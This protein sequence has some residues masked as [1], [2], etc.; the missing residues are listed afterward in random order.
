MHTLI[1]QDQ[2][3]A[4]VADPNYRTPPTRKR[5]IADHIVAQAPDVQQ[6]LRELWLD[7]SFNPEERRFV[8]ALFGG[9]EETV[10]V[11]PATA[12]PAELAAVAQ[13]AAGKGKPR[14][15]QAAHAPAPTGAVAPTS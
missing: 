12:T 5:E 4:L 14:P 11:D 3:D 1:P 8:A 7:N 10:V 2:I 15:S 9:A 6:K 13:P